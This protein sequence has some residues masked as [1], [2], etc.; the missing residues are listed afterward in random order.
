[1]ENTGDQGT[2]PAGPSSQPGAPAA[3]PMSW[4]NQAPPP[5]SWPNPVQLPPA[6]KP[7][8]LT[9]TVVLLTVIT[10]SC[11]GYISVNT[12]R[13][14]T[15]VAGKRPAGAGSTATARVSAPTSKP[16]PVRGK[17]PAGSK[18]SSY[19]VR[20]AKD[21]ER[22]CDRWYYPKSPKYLGAAPHPIAITVK[23][24]LSW[25][26]RTAVTSIDLPYEATAAVEAAWQPKD[27]TAVQV[28]A[29]VDLITTGPRVATCRVTD[30]K[31]E[32]VV[33]KEGVYRLSL[34]EVSTR[35][36]LLQVRMSGENE[37]CPWLIMVGADGKAISAVHDRQLVE[38]LR[39][40]V[41]Q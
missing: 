27:P 16:A 41:E 24:S 32:K 1:M 10:L 12:L 15:P 40:Y 38:T 22:V 6:K 35:R 25:G 18:A 19:P 26:G 21:L 9:W 3:P 28:V 23:D 29:C 13:G 39:R 4:P 37:D 17:V 20:N 11:V 14:D 34:Y 5:M 30:P 7:S 8:R 2:Q 33:M 31:P 36:R